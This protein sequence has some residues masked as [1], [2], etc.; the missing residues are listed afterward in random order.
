MNINI[1]PSIIPIGKILI[2]KNNESQ[3]KYLST[4]LKIN[5][6]LFQRTYDW[7]EDKLYRLL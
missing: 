3:T 5:I 7:D 6:P 4:P 2:A 1:E